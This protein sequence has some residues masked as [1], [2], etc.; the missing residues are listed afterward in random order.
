M[1]TLITHV[2][3]HVIIIIPD[4]QPVDWNIVGTGYVSY[5]V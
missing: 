4:T 5:I 3:I 1:A 2:S